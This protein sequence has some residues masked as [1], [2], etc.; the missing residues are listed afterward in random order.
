MSGEQVTVVVE[1][2]RRRAPGGVGTYARGLLD[3]LRSLGPEAPELT[4]HASRS[5]IRPDPLGVFGFRV[6]ASPFPARGLTRLWD[7]GMVGVPGPDV[8]HCVSQATPP[9]RRGQHLVAMVHDLAWREAPDTFPARGRRW[10]EASLRR[11]LARASAVV[12]PSERTAAA[13]AGALAA[14][15]AAARPAARPPRIEVIPHG[16]DH[17]PPPDGAG[18]AAALARFGIRGPYLLSVSTL[19]PR[20]NLA[21]LIDAYSR[22]RPRL[23]EPWPLVVVGPAGWGP[24]LEPAPGVVLTG[25]V[26]A[27][28]LSALYAGARCLAYV[29]LVEG[30]GLPPVEAMRQGTAVVA[31]PMPSTGGAALEVEPTD[32]GAMAAAL[33]DAASDGSLRA[34]LIDRGRR[35]AEELTWRTAAERHVRLW[36]SLGAGR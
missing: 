1:Q 34:T 25:A 8:V 15:R 4:L 5:P 2:L 35:R 26:D 23:P 22:A 7:W 17:L 28:V 12:V 30:F 21:R 10:H 24:A 11:C 9:G 16:S 14:A 32:V 18:A 13:L 36:R 3:G 19:E 20:K 6:D 31:S 33:A 27:A 29:P